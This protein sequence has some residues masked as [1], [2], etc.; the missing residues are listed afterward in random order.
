MDRWLI[1][2]PL[3]GISALVNDSAV[4][5][6]RRG[7][8]VGD[9]E[10]EW[11]SQELR[12][13]PPSVPR[14]ITDNVVVPSFL[15]I[16]PTRGCNIACDYCNFGGPSAS[17]KFMDPKVA[18]AAV[19]W[20]ADRLQAAGRTQFMVHFFGGEPFIARDIIDIVVHRVR[21]LAQERGLTPYFDASTNGVF[22][23]QMCQFIGEYFHSVVLSFDGFARHHDRN[24]SGRKRK[25]TH[26]IVERTARTLSEMP[27]DLCLRVCI[28]NRSVSQME[29]ITRWM[30]ESFGPAIINFE[31]LTHG[32]LAE[33][34]GLLPPD[35]I[36]F[37]IHCVRSMR[38]ARELG[39]QVVYSASEID[40]KRISFCPV[41]SDALIVEFDGRVSGCYLLPEDWHRRGLDMDLGR[42]QSDG[43]DLDF[44]AITRVRQLPLDKPR[45][46]RC[47]C[48]WSCAGGCHVNQT[49]PAC[50]DDY[51]DFCVQTRIITVCRL[52]DELGCN[53]LV[54]ELL[55]DRSGLERLGQHRS[56]IMD[57]IMDYVTDDIV[58]PIGV[59]HG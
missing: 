36:E 16:I 31:P 44:D 4:G 53:A 21:W 27:I 13:P 49:Y 29:E 33:R 11:L 45:C 34:A 9:P 10:I 7:Q 41:G 24:R 30:C 28:T 20:M 59:S 18:V 22:D 26:R 32:E 43:M 52:L 39:Y 23:Q 58:A 50:G 15:G 47:G 55:A 35:P 37:A 19:D 48:Q 38:L 51:N 12:A 54:D 5:K 46:R 40:Q 42:C 57:D 14:A 25:A 6:L 3:H 8:V 56:D 17:V 2:S 1:Y